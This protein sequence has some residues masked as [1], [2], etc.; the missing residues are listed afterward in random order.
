MNIQ[1]RS[2]LRHLSLVLFLTVVASFSVVA[3]SEEE[4]LPAVVVPLAPIDTLYH[5]S[6]NQNIKVFEPRAERVRDHAEKAVV[7]ATPSF[8][9]ASCYLFRWD[10]SWVFQSVLPEDDKAGYKVRMVIAD[11]ERFLNEDKGGAIYIL[12]SKSFGFS[13]DKGLGIYEW[14]SQEK[15]IPFAQ[16]NFTSALEAMEKLGVQL[17]F[18]DAEQFKHVL[19]LYGKERDEFLKSLKRPAA[20][21]GDH[22]PTSYTPRPE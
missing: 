20:R 7:F 15:V 9:L 11:K 12:P 18:V 13:K 10:N 3:A 17:H 2:F 21:A 1:S 4:Q 22:Q 5:A 14:T 8:R 6:L 16:L 19:S